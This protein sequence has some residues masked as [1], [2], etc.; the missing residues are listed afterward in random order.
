MTL[1]Y[2]HMLSLLMSFRTLLFNGIAKESTF[3]QLGMI[4]VRVVRFF[5]KT[6]NQTVYAIL[7]ISQTVPHHEKL[8]PYKPHHEKAVRLRF[9]HLNNLLKL[10]FA[11]EKVCPLS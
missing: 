11:G 1:V 2:V 4:A 8:K 9:M 10:C 5:A 3:L 6:A 7:S